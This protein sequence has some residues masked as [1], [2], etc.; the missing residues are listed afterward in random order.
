MGLLS[1]DEQPAFG[2]FPQMKP[3]RIKQDPEAAKSAPV[4]LGRGFVAGALGVPGD[5]EALVRMATG[6]KQ[7]LPTSSYIESKLP[8]K[9][10]TPV[11]NAAAGL[12]QMLGGFYTGPGS[13]VR[14][15][16]AVPG[17]VKRAAQDFVQSAGQ[18]V[19]PMREFRVGDWG[20]DQR[21]D[22]R[23]LEQQRLHDLTTV[24]N[25]RQMKPSPV[26]SLVDYEGRPFITSM[27]DRTAA[28][29]ELV[30]IN[31]V[32]LNRPVDLRGGQDY[33]FDNNPGQVW[34]SGKNPVKQILGLAKDVKAVTGQ[35]PLFMPWRMAPSGGDFAQMT[36][37]TMLNFADASLGKAAKARL[38][39]QMRD[40]IPEWKSVSSDAAVD[41]FRAAPDRTRKAIKSML[42]RDFRESGGL[43]IGEARLAVTDP[44]QLTAKD[45]GLMNVGLISADGPMITKSGH[46]AY[47][48]GVP[49]E[50]IGHLP[51]DIGVFQLLTD[52][53]R[54]RKIPDAATPRATDLRALQMKPYAG[55]IDESLLRGLDDLG[56]LR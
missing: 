46:P 48:F 23:K 56:L 6:G 16:T 44:L 25:E 29:G 36:G 47:P 2:F 33:M 21:F 17:A 39:R 15:V 12:G 24:V 37:E 11:G 54:S 34:A 28:G 45:G 49:G 14:A 50:G 20:F 18:T 42:D 3:R 1:T 27:S 10:D 31:G 19:S 43:G 26:V 8:F 40:F 9:S 4:D 51:Q 13:G 30:K 22:P 55:I 53:A 7:I 5:L 35:D 32:T 38:D 52:A 41:Q